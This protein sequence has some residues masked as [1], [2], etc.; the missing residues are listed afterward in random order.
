MKT[1]TRLAR[2]ALGLALAIISG[3]SQGTKPPPQSVA[4]TAPAKSEPAAATATEASSPSTGWRSIASLPE[5]AMDASPQQQLVYRM[6]VVSHPLEAPVAL[7]VDEAASS[8]PS[9]ALPKPTLIHLFFGTSRQPAP[10]S[11]SK[12]DKHPRYYGNDWRIN[13]LEYGVCW[14]TMPTDKE[15]PPG[16][17]EGSTWFWFDLPDNPREDVWMQPPSR[18]GGPSEFSAALV[19]DIRKRP[20]RSVLIGVHGFHNTFEFAG[21]RLAKMVHDMNYHGTPVLYS[22]P[23]GEGIEDYGHDEDLVAQPAEID[24]FAGFLD[25]VI[26]TAQEAGARRVHLVAHSMGNRLLQHAAFRLGKL[27]A[28]SRRTPPL[29]T[30]VLAAPDIPRRGFAETIWPRLTNFTQH[31]AL[32]VSAYDRALFGSEKIHRSGPRLGQAGEVPLVLAGLETIDSSRLKN[33]FLHHD[34][35]LR[36]AGICDLSACLVR[37]MS[38]AERVMRGLLHRAGN[39]PNAAWYELLPGDGSDCLRQ[40]GPESALP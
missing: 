39:P 7:T 10:A 27:Y 3:C 11:L 32:Y 38:P 33:T 26:A 18:F 17:I 29:D 30:V 14:V 37:S 25:L 13:S 12:P 5:A 23:A 28:D 8:G 2:S 31:C 22:W 4:P 36:L 34:D 1:P 9:P 16:E 24:N 20:D 19:Q 35:H 15:L 40:I 6:E 21:R